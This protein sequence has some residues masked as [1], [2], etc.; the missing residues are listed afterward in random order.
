MSQCAESARVFPARCKHLRR[1]SASLIASTPGD[2]QACAETMASKSPRLT[3]TDSR[4]PP[5]HTSG[6]WRSPRQPP[7]TIPSLP[8]PPIFSLSVGGNWG[9]SEIKKRMSRTG[10]CHWAFLFWSGHGEHSFKKKKKS[11]KRYCLE[12]LGGVV[13]CAD[14]IPSWR[15]RTVAWVCVFVGLQFDGGKESP[16]LCGEQF[17]TQAIKLQLTSDTWLNKLRQNCHVGPFGSLFD[18]PPQFG[19][20]GPKPKGQSSQ[21]H[22]AAYAGKRIFT[23]TDRWRL[24]PM[25]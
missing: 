9:G 19:T 24:I 15:W 25:S 4:L 18:I 3:A 17:S 23:D 8:P 12:G 10:T 7:P 1:E 6:P 14:V 2:R 13:L 20:P 5:K 11:L 21:N 16:E 22:W